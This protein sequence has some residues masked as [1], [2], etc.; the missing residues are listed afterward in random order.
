MPKVPIILFTM[1]GEAADRL[2]PAVGV[3]MVISKPDGVQNLLQ[4]VHGLLNSRSIQ[5]NDR[6][7]HA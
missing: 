3:D 6:T 5:D 1:Y 7:L 2:G 4:K